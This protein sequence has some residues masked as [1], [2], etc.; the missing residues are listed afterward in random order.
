MKSESM[1]KHLEAICKKQ[2]EDIKNLKVDLDKAYILIEEWKKTVAVFFR[3]HANKI[4]FQEKT[5]GGRYYP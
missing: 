3:F 1:E 5:R 2:E 4:F